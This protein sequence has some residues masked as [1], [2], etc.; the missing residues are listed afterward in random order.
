[1]PILKNNHH[2]N[3]ILPDGT[4]IRRGGPAVTMA[5]EK[6]ARELKNPVVAAW[7][8]LGWVLVEG[9]GKAGPP[10]MTGNYFITDPAPDP[11][12]DEADPRDDLR[13]EARSL[14]I[15]V[16]NRWGEKRLREEIDKALAE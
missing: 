5:A 2:G 13:E 15:E 1:M 14:G 12:A 7:V 6:W 16:D 10:P 3:L 8:D 11:E 4:A 9:D